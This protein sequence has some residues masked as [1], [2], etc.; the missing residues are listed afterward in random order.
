MLEKL[1]TSSLKSA[2]AES[3]KI[4]DAFLTQD[5][6]VNL[7]VAAPKANAYEFQAQGIVDM[8]TKLGG[9]FGDERTELR[10][11]RQTRVT[12]LRSSPRT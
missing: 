8:L 1:L 10:R 3:K 9:K 12:L 5:P 11:R 4:I 2:R 6:D 7:T